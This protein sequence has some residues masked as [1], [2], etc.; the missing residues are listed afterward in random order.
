MMRQMK[1]AALAIAVTL[2]LSGF[3]L[4]QDRDD[5][6]DGYYQQGNSAQARQYGYQNGYRDGYSKGRH[7]GRENDPNDY[8]TPDWRQAT[9]GYQQWMGPVSWF[10]RGYRDGYS[11]GFR[12]GYLSASR[13]DGDGDR[14]YQPYYGGNYPYGNDPYYGN[15][16][17]SRG[18]V[19]Y[20]TGYQDGASVAREDRSS[21]KRYNPNP[22][23]RYDDEDHGYR[24]EYG[25]KGAYK[26]QYAS[27]YRT[28]YQATF[29]NRY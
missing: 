14:D 7:E 21:G 3:A 29:G 28:G 13:G 1:I 8:R 27:G 20:N 19:A 18:N 26:T 4:A 17:W 24:S 5:D 10:Q 25:N 6:D 16:T 23:G 2:V 12:N 22:R 15:Q 11:N 9:R